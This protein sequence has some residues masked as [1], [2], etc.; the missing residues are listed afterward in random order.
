MNSIRNPQEKNVWTGKRAKHASALLS[1][2]LLVMY[3]IIFLVNEN[4][5]LF[6]KKKKRMGL[7][8]NVM[9]EGIGIDGKGCTDLEGNLRKS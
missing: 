7:V 3:H 8:E 4:S 9:I 1:T 5:R 2:M 6:Y